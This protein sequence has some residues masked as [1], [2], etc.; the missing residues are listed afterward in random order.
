MAY[1]SPAVNPKACFNQPLQTDRIA[2]KRSFLMSNSE[3]AQFIGRV[4]AALVADSGIMKKV[5]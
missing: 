4:V 5:A 1:F 2:I 3:S